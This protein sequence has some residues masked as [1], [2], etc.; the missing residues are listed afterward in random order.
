MRTVNWLFGH[1][2]F[3]KCPYEEIRHFVSTS[4]EKEITHAMY[5]LFLSGEKP[6]EFDRFIQRLSD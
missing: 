2:P 5:L 6:E 3:S 1:L 4:T